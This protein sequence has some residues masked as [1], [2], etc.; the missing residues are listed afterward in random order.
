MHFLNEK[1]PWS[2]SY[3]FNMMVDFCIW[4]LE[5]D[6][7]QVT[8][9][10]QHPEG[11]HSLRNAGLDAEN[12]LSWVMRVVNLQYEQQQALQQLTRSAPPDS[13]KILQTLHASNA[14]NPPEAWAGNENVKNRLS[15]LWQQYGPISNE[16]KRREMQLSRKLRL[17]ERQKAT[18]LYDELKPY[19]KRIPTLIIHLVSYAQPLDVLFPPL[20]VIMTAA[21][22]Q[23]DAAAFRERVLDAAEGLTNNR[24]VR[25]RNQSTY[26]PIAQ[27]P[28]LSYKIYPRQPVQTAPPRPRVHPVAETEAKQIILDMLN[29][30]NSHFGDANMAT[31][32]FDKEKNTPGWQM[33]YISF[34]E[35]DEGQKHLV[36]I[37]KQHKDGKWH[38]NSASTGGNIRERDRYMVPVHDH[39]LIFLSGG[40]K[41]NAKKYDEDGQY[42]FVAYGDVIDNGF[43]V[44]HVRLLNDDGQVF[45]DTVQDGLVL[46]ASVQ[47]QEVQWPMQAELYNSEGKLVWRQPVFDFRPFM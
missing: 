31:V 46:F 41:G 21:E 30:E 4:I 34:E 13:Q 32:Q 33:H 36:V 15:E 8:P 17:A 37:L 18:R 24:S 9:F 2:Y 25:Q 35:A 45:E 26:I 10:D 3:D 44:T 11:D 29:N 42:E 39:P 1:N 19:Q 5:T 14:N 27:Q 6:G 28:M 38:L 47:D 22:G 12:W 7:L 40:R 16:R 20:S 23:P 43:N